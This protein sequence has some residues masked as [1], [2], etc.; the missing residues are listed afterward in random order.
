MK[1]NLLSII[2]LAL[3]VVNLIVSIVM[4]VSV[5]SASRKTTA[6]V[7]DIAAIIG[8]EIDGL[9]QS[10]IAGAVSMENTQTH[11]VEDELTISLKKGEDGK[12]HFAIVKV[13]LSMN[14]KHDDFEKYSAD[15]A[16]KEGLITGIVIEV[17]S[18]YTA[19]EAREN[20]NN[21][22]KEILK[23]IQSLYGSDFIYSITFR[24]IL[25]Q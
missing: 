19:E 2:I 6:L 12:D 1:K 24:N 20:T 16:S 15:I 7:A 17:F 8:I 11:N 4:M 3:L 23:E 13:S 25:I 22:R 9:K 21:I 18:K 5:T 14:T 10:D